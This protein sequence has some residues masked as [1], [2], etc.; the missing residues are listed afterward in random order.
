MD[1]RF[2]NGKTSKN[3]RTVGE[4]VDELSRLPR[5]LRV[6]QGFSPSADVVVFNVRTPD[7]YVTLADGG[8]WDHEADIESQDL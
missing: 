6:T 3:V 2:S 1:K 4:L 8:L 7:I 5:D